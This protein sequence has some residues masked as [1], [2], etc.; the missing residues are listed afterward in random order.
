[1]DCNK[2]DPTHLS[3]HVSRLLTKQPE[4]VF[5]NISS[6]NDDDDEEDDDD[7]DDLSR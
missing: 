2:P 7:D 5:D 1:M 4:K 3:H 6:D